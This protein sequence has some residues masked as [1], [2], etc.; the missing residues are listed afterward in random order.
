MKKQIVN[1]KPHILQFILKPKGNFPNSNFP[2]LVY[3]K[4]LLFAKE[5][6]EAGAIAEEVFRKNDWGNTWLNGIYDFHHFH[7][8][9][10]E[11]LAIACGN[12]EVILGGLEGRKVAM[13]AG[14]VIVIPAGVA[15][16]RI[17]ASPDFLCVGGYPRG[18]D[19]DICRGKENEFEAA[20]KTTQQIPA[21][22]TDPVYGKEGFIKKYWEASL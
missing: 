19:Y 4:A 13:H 3:K 8:N 15:H 16:K 2:V 12:V 17:F 18:K 6:T 10:H 5:E 20:L 9:T 1:A 22:D 14:D 7:S 11:A 21:P